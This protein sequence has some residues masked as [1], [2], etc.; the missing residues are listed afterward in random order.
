[1]TSRAFGT[2]P[3]LIAK[4]KGS[5]LYALEGMKFRVGVPVHPTEN[6]VALK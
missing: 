4:P 2:E 6:L 5:Y 1:M 3:E